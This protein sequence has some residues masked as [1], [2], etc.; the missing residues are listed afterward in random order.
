MTAPAYKFL[1][2]SNPNLDFDLT[3]NKL[4][5]KQHLG[6]TYQRLV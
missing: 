4:E 3:I 2:K 1:K 5:K 6:D